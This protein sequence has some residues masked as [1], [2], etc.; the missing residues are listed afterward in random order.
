MTAERTPTKTDARIHRI[1]PVAVV[2]QIVLTAGGRFLLG[3]AAFRAGSTHDVLNR[4]T[5]DYSV[6][7]SARQPPITK[8][9]L[10]LAQSTA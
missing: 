3:Y 9:A 2:A 8:M 10:T 6:L 1:W 4:T 5:T 7:A